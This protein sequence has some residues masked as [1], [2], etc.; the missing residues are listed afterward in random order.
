MNQTQVLLHF[1]NLI[2]EIW[3]KFFHLVNC[4]NLYIFLA[5]LILLQGRNVL[6]YLAIEEIAAEDF[7]VTVAVRVRPFNQRYSY[8]CKTCNL[9]VSFEPGQRSTY[10][11]RLSY[12]RSLYCKNCFKKKCIHLA[13]HKWSNKFYVC[14]QKNFLMKLKAK[15]HLSYKIVIWVKIIDKLSQLVFQEIKKTAGVH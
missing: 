4:F 6:F 10:V 11:L 13:K 8:G 7:S 15:I 3:H 1:P 2:L 9:F 12:K 14:Y 5:F